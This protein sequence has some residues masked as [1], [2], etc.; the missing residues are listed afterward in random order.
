MYIIYWLVNENKDKT[1]IGFTK[2]IAQRINYHVDKKVKTTEDFG[3]FKCF[4]L[5]RVE[6][7][8]SARKREKYWKSCAGRKKLKML[9]D[10]II[11]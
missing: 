1:Y 9:F 8:I 11:V 7:L 4:I 2:D 5:E 6:D 10:K 3:K